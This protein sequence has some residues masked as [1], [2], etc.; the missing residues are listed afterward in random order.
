MTFYNVLSALLFL[1]SLRVLLLAIEAGNWR[2][3]FTAG[4]LVVIVFN[5]MLSTSNVVESIKETAYTLPLMLIDLVNFM[6]LAL[7]TVI[8]S[9]KKNLFDIE[10]PRISAALGA[11]SFWL[12]LVLYWL[13]LML[14]TRISCVP[15]KQ[16]RKVVLRQWTVVIA[17]AVM[18]LLYLLGCTGITTPA[19]LVVLVYLIL[20][21]VGI[22]R[23]FDKEPAAAA[24]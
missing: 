18:W 16:E 17:F 21:L 11:A 15:K 23:I 24:S 4:C 8:L 9:P 10:V 1:G 7:G 5:D 14:W 19:T 20:Y 6:L 13:L 22:W 3:I 12:L 2:G